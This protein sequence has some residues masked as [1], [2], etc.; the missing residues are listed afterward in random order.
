MQP[1]SQQSVAGKI[2]G[3]PRWAA[4]VARDRGAD[5][6]FFYSVRTTGVYCRPSCG[7][8]LARPENV[9][10]H[11]TPADAE[12]AGFRPCKRCRPNLS[13]PVD[14]DAARVAAACRRIES[15]EAAPT[16][17]Q[18]ACE[19]G[20]SR[21]HFHRLFKAV[22]GLTPRAYGDALRA[23]RV[24]AA[25][26]GGEGVTRAVVEAGYGS[27]SRFYERAD[28]LLGMRPS[29]YRAGADGEDVRYALAHC[30]LGQVLVA[31]TAK[32]I[33]EVALGDDASQLIERLH[34]RFARARQCD[35]DASLREW[36]AAVVR[37]VDRPGGR[38]D[39]PLDIRGTVFQQRVWRALL[40]MAPGT[41]ATYAEL[42]ARVGR[43]A[44]A[45]AVAGACA[46][47]NIAVLIPCHRVVRSDGALSGYRWGP[48][49]KRVLLRRESGE[50]EAE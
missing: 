45:R 23:A 50:D 39:L 13:L 8:R 35:E 31:A 38:C 41:T 29:T 36:V 20:L 7:A 42:A 14:P 5:G 34:A 47:N 19:A 32:G 46:A 33:C 6:R 44:A 18:L 21:F 48:Q 11:D 15:A 10:F 30:S 25:L 16:L 17:E 9:Q 40:E 24:R 3:D 1:T 26:T 28:H 43:P 2:T 37:M 12:R 49:R 22:T 4:L 27:S